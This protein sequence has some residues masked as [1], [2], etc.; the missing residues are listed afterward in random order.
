MAVTYSSYLKLDEL[1]ALQQPRSPGPEHDEMLFIIIHQVY[2]LWFKE[3]LHELAYLETLLRDNAT[4]RALHTLK[5]VLTVL[6][7]MVAQIDVLETMTPLEFLSFRDRLESGSGFQSFQFREL[8]FVLGTKNPVALS[9]Y[10]EGSEARRR[11]EARY[12]ESTLWDAFLAYLVRNQYAVPPSSLSR[13]VTRP[14]EPSREMQKVLIEVY[15]TNPAVA[16]VCER[17]VDLDEGIMEWR[18]RH[19]KMVQRTIGTKPGT[20]GSA[21]AEYLETTLNKPAFPDLWAIRTEL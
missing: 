9:R 10:P 15:R 11:L 14:L 17:L 3:M 12:R 16:S 13:E 1:L 4:P 8:E 19:V 7:V 5:R 18:Y 2:E 6:K 21:G 20:G